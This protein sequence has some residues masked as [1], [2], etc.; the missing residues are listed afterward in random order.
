MMSS[1][2]YD[3]GHNAAVLNTIAVKLIFTI[4]YKT[5]KSGSLGLSP[6][7]LTISVKGLT[8]IF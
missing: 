4:Y 6:C 8:Q 5:M 2:F 3:L 1:Y 7:M